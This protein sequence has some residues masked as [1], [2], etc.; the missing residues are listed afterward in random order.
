RH[1]AVASAPAAEGQDVSR[2]EEV[3]QKGYMLHDRILRSA[4]VKVSLPGS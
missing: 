3:F 2:V 1:E 4:K